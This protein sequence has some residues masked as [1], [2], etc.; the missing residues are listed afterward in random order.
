MLIFI[1][2][3]LAKMMT[4]GAMKKKSPSNQSCHLQPSMSNTSLCSLSL[5]QHQAPQITV[6][7]FFHTTP[8]QVWCPFVRM[9]CWTPSKCC[10]VLCALTIRIP[11]WLST[12]PGLLL[13]CFLHL[14]SNTIGLHDQQHTHIHTHMHR[15]RGC[16]N[17]GRSL[18]LDISSEK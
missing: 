14:Y 17:T 10:L 6:S 13:G 11:H 8:A 3:S 7:L 16:K 15:G 4:K 12:P 1:W 2:A 18:L 9:L 5:R